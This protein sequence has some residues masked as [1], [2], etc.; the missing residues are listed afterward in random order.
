MLH[1]CSKELFLVLICSMWRCWINEWEHYIMKQVPLFRMILTSKGHGEVFSLLIRQDKTVGGW[2]AGVTRRHWNK[3]KLLFCFT[4]GGF[5]NAACRD[6]EI[7]CYKMSLEV[8]REK[9]STQCGNCCHIYEQLCVPFV[10]LS[11]Q[12]ALQ[13]LSSLSKL[14]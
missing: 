10:R 11:K 14:S 4:W 5:F 2:R 3:A 13:I 9:C 8:N 6:V 12:R 7:N 1:C